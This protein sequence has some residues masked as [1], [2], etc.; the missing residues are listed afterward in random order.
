MFTANSVSW[1][2]SNVERA[3]EVS[4]HRPCLH[5]SYYEVSFTSHGNWLLVGIFLNDAVNGLG[6]LNRDLLVDMKA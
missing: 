6:V 3:L 2:A 1:H 5:N 4:L